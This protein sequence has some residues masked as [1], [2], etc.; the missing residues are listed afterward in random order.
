[1]TKRRRRRVSLGLS[2]QE[3]I[4]QVRGKL[5][6]LVDLA[7]RASEAAE[8]GHCHL[9]LRYYVEARMAGAVAAA[10]FM[11]TGKR[12]GFAGTFLPSARAL[13]KA[14]GQFERFCMRSPIRKKQIR[15]IERR[16]PGDWEK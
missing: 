7:E 10:H 1:M 15:N 13:K 6:G 14:T 12:R 9:A 11:S 4:R 8:A 16:Q 5:Q 3:H 2:P